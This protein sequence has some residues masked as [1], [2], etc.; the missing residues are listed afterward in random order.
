[1][2]TDIK[3]KLLRNRVVNEQETRLEPSQL[4]PRLGDGVFNAG[5][6]AVGEK[7]EEA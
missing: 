4:L 6:P 7:K 5:K 3:Y 2:Q 1:M